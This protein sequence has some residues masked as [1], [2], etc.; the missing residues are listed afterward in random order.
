[1]SE[2]DYRRQGIAGGAEFAALTGFAG[3][4]LTGA[5][6]GAHVIHVRAVIHVGR[7]VVLRG[8]TGVCHGAAVRLDIHERICRGRERHGYSKQEHE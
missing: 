3:V 2:A 4:V 1:M 6:R 5:M 7:H 8:R